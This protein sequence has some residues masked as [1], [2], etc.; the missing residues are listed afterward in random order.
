MNSSTSPPRLIGS[1]GPSACPGRILPAL[2]PSRQ[3]AQ[4]RRSTPANRTARG[5]LQCLGETPWAAPSWMDRLTD[6]QTTPL[7]AVLTK[8]IY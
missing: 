2:L 4:G 5:N 6:R 3:R 7:Q 1:R 8:E